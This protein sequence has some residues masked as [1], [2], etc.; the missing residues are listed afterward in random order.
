MVSP[1]ESCSR[2]DSPIP[3]VWAHEGVGNSY[4]VSWDTTLAAGENVYYEEP[5]APPLPGL[6]WSTGYAL[7]RNGTHSHY[8]SSLDKKTNGCLFKTCS[9]KSSEPRLSQLTFRFTCN[10]DNT[11]DVSCHGT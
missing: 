8:L 11:I 2:S 3:R 7:L 1:L 10:H 5:L 6:H 4:H 9:S